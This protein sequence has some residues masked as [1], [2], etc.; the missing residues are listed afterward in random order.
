M[1]LPHEHKTG[2]PAPEP[3][4]I[5]SWASTENAAPRLT[6]HRLMRFMNVD[7]PRAGAPRGVNH[8]ISPDEP[9]SEDES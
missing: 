6:K 7:V 8:V 1:P 3:R 4:G 2:K 9:V 5:L